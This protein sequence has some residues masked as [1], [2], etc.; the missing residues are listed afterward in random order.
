MPRTLHATAVLLALGVLVLTAVAAFAAEDPYRP[1]QWGLERIGAPSAWERTVGAGI[2][3]A[4]L[5]TGIDLEHPDLRD[6]LL[7]DGDG[8]VVGRD[9]VDGDRV[10]QDENGHGTMVAGIAL[11]MADNGEGIAGVAPG[12]WLMPVRVLGPDGAGRHSDLDEGIRW[13]VD[14]GADVINLSL[15]RADQPG[16]VAGTVE[17]L[18]TPVSAV[19][20]AWDRG[21][22]VVA[23]AGNSGNDVT[24]YPDDSPVLLV[25]ATD[26]DDRKTGF[27]DA[28]RRD[29]VVAPGVEIVSTWCDPEDGGCDPGHR[30]GVASGTSF[31][32]PSVAGAIALLLSQGLDHREAVERIRWTAQDLGPDG[33][34]AQTGHGLV[35]VDAATASGPGPTAPPASPPSSPSPEATGDVSSAD[36]EGPTAT[37]TTPSA[38]PTPGE[39]SPAEAPTAPSTAPPTPTDPSPIAAPGPP[40]GQDRAPWLGLTTVLVVLTAGAVGVNLYRHGGPGFDGKRVWGGP[41]VKSRR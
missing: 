7:R 35:D 9:F 18:T 38:T 28:G 19:E 4:V 30:Y 12:A 24:D 22:V 2:V 20:Y 10:P 11:A 25:G 13:A 39:P 34:D 41:V 6:R 3:V 17:G 23:A 15:E 14:A 37:T 29:A 27:S 16:I 8:R 32:A 40:S 33:P 1:Q 26:R 21:V 36:E 31:A 5:D